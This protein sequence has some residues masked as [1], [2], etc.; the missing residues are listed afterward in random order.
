MKNKAV[1]TF[2]FLISL[3]LPLKAAEEMPLFTNADRVLVLATHPDDET[4]GAAGAIQKAI[5]AGAVVR[6]VYYTNGDSNEPAFSVYERRLTFL[7]GEFLHMGEVRIQE[8]ISAMS[9]LGLSRKDLTFLGYPDAG[10]MAIF[11]QY[12]GDTKPF[13]ALFTRVSKVPYPECISPGA[14]YVGESIL[15]DIKKIILKIIEKRP[16]N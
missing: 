2:L 9:D 12:W 14:P 5:K 4:I 11:T 8:A 6:V 7:K 3:A 10:T 15:K 16:E 13:K 1:L